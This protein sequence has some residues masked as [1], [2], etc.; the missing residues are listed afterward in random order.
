MPSNKVLGRRTSCP[1]LGASFR[2]APSSSGLLKNPIQKEYVQNWQHTCRRASRFSQ[3]QVPHT[4]LDKCQSTEGQVPAGASSAEANQ[5]ADALDDKLKLAPILARRLDAV[6]HSSG[7]FSSRVCMWLIAIHKQM[8]RY[9]SHT[10]TCYTLQSSST[11]KSGSPRQP[12]P[13]RRV[14]NS[15]VHEYTKVCVEFFVYVHFVAP[16]AY[17]QSGFVQ[18]PSLLRTIEGRNLGSS[19]L[20]GSSYLPQVSIV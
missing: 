10:C 9:P 6:S 8:D 14:S 7:S 18:L 1:D 16:P 13:K 15:S 2:C 3:D 17:A 4:S 12:S 19:P 5:L 11:P 20:V